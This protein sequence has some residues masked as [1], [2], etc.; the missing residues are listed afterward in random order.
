[1]PP[2]EDPQISLLQYLVEV[3]DFAFV[4]I[5]TLVPSAWSKHIP[6]LFS[7]FSLA[8]PRRYVE[9]GAHFGSSFF[10]A[11]QATKRLSLETECV[12][13]DTW[14]G[15]HQAGHYTEEVFDSFRH[16]LRTRYPAN[17]Y[18]VRT[19][20][21][22]AAPLFEPGSIDVLHIDGLHT[23][24]QV[25]RDFDTWL[26]KMSS[27]GIILMHDTN[28][29][30]G[31]FGVWRLWEKLEQVYPALNLRHT[32]GLGII[33]VGKDDW[34]V[35]RLIRE[36]R[37]RPDAVQLL[38]SLYRSVGELSVT[39]A[40]RANELQDQRGEISALR[41]EVSTATERANELQDQKREIEMLREE[42]ARAAQRASDLLI[43]E[44]AASTSELQRQIA[45]AHAQVEALLSST[46]WKVTKPLR[47]FSR[48]LRRR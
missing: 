2:G 5:E 22:D 40:Q 37:D 48:F 32:H 3:L 21:A 11:C 30:D 20:F 36:V 24:D 42:I 14:K 43:S 13:I 17:T 46:S 38:N 47:G 23:Y 6:L 10:A 8:R 1:M 34:E 31:D 26:P 4:P 41:A 25:K 19:K 18:Y 44:R 9:L 39:A 12:A 33:Y 29:Y 27:R 28:V 15:D 45:T 16:L 35:P 7:I